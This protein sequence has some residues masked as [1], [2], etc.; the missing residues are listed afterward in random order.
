M[1]VKVSGIIT[2]SS[3]SYVAQAENIAFTEGGAAVTL[4][5]KLATLI[6]QV[7][8]LAESVGSGTAADIIYE[9]ST[10]IKQKITSLESN[11]GTTA[12]RI[13]YT[14]TSG[15]NEVTTNVKAVLDDLRA[16]LDN[17]EDLPAI[18]QRLAQYA[19]RAETASGAA[20]TSLETI[21]SKTEELT[22]LK[23]QAASL[24][25]ATI[26]KINALEAI[27]QDLQA[28]FSYDAEFRLISRDAY[29]QL[30]LNGDVN[31][32]TVY[33]IYDDTTSQASV[34]YYSVLVTTE[35]GNTLEGTPIGTGSYAAN[36]E[37]TIAAVPKTGYQ[38]DHWL[39]D[40]S[41]VVSE[42]PTKLTVNAARSAIAYFQP[43]SSTP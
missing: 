15:G 5:L 6:Q 29:N 39:I 1:A 42:N 30:E 38:F 12:D 10:T 17:I 27:A 37:I 21:R 23:N 8:T 32:S 11:L 20:Q 19:S 14:Y 2:P 7:A 25:Q 41:D 33:L 34:T 28:T 31:S 43:I 4:Q 26:G 18:E 22:E 13:S 3:G 35:T 36:S 24:N 9:G 16:A 40:G